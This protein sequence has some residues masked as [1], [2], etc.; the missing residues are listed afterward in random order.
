MVEIAIVLDMNCSAFPLTWKIS[1]VS[2]E[3]ELQEICPISVSP[4]GKQ[5]HTCDALVWHGHLSTDSRIM[6]ENRR[7]W[8][9]PWRCQFQNKP[10]FFLFDGMKCISAESPACWIFYLIFFTFEKPSASYSPMHSSAR[11]P[12]P[13]HLSVPGIL[14]Y[15]S[16][17]SEL[18]H[19][20]FYGILWFS[21][22]FN[23]IL[24]LRPISV[25]EMSLWVNVASSWESRSKKGQT[26]K[27]E[28]LK[29]TK[30]W[31]CPAAWEKLEVPMSSC[32]E[33]PHPSIIFP[34]ALPSFAAQSVAI[35]TLL[36]QTLWYTESIFFHAYN[37]RWLLFEKPSSQY[38]R[39]KVK[40]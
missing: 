22:V 15:W 2:E 4:R 34:D 37:K 8:N 32:W 14:F 13:M 29:K 18:Q 9:A 26:W 35:F 10:F 23:N 16:M 27:K 5:G 6:C 20:K 1:V 30:G 24:C 21:G 12:Q 28:R 36:F 38:K 31:R 40:R 25:I 7:V 39:K 19:L 3:E 33:H 11:Y 17:A